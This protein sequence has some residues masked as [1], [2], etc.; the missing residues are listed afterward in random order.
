MREV[1]S[2]S[3]HKRK[4]ESF[5]NS[6]KEQKMKQ[7][8]YWFSLMAAI[9][10]AFT[11]H[12]AALAAGQPIPFKGQSR[13]LV[14]ATGFDPVAGIAYI[15]VA[16]EGEATH[17]GHFLVNAD[18][19]VDVATGIP[20]GSWTLT[21]ANGDKLFLAMGGYGIDPTHGFGAFT[22]VGGTGR[23]AGAT[24]YYEQIITFSAQPGSVAVVSYS[25]VLAGTITVEQP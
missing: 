10:V 5:T 21:A 13:G 11:L 22:V 8:L 24:G 23:F 20:Q 18:V 9:L 1:L 4:T 17:L 2:H 14:T 6:K 15:H 3:P 19:G 25:D 16:G 12:G 7:R